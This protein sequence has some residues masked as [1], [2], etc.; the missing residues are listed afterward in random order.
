LNTVNRRSL[1]VGSLGA[2]L[3][4]PALAQV[5]DGCGNQPKTAPALQPP[6]LL[7]DWAWLG[8]YREDNEKLS[9]AGAKVDTVFLGDSITE[10]WASND[11]EFFSKGIVGRGIS[12]QTTPQLLVRMY[13]D[14]IALKPRVVHI[15]AGTND[16]AHNTGP[17]TAQDT[18][19]NV[20]AMCDIAKAHRIHVVLGS[21]PPASKYWWHPGLQP[22]PEA[23]AMNEWLRTYAKKIGA[24]FADYASAFVDAKGDVKPELA[25]DEVHPTL[26]GYAVMRPMAQAAIAAAARS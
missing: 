25:Q 17:M 5:P 23:L 10:G 3:A 7:T 6:L 14:V 15:M 26:A 12:A 21:V 2:G 1:I 8:R 9:A 4:L 19:N 11:K 22:K 18:H 20:M 13:Q 16:I 24:Q